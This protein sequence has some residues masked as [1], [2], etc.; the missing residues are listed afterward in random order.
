MKRS[1]IEQPPIELAFSF[2]PARWPEFI[3]MNKSFLRGKAIDTRAAREDW[4]I[5]ASH[6]RAFDH[7]RRLAGATPRRAT[8]AG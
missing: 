3:A 1:G 4:R 2:P 5:S 6:R 8:A 7:E